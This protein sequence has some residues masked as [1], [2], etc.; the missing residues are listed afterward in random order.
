MGHE[1]EKVDR[2][3]VLEAGVAGVAL[4]VLPAACSS[5]T[6]SSTDAGTDVKHDSTPHD[7]PPPDVTPKDSAGDVYDPDATLVDG[8]DMCESEQTNWTHPINIM[9]AGIALKGTAYAFND[10]RFSDRYQQ[11]DRILVI[12]PLTGTGYVAM[13]G[14]CTHA[15]CCP[16][17][18]PKCI[19]STPES[20]YTA[21]C[22]P[23]PD[24]GLPDAG[25][26]GGIPDGSIE[27]P[28]GGYV[29]GG[30][31]EL[32]TDILFCPCH[33]S[34]YDA[35]TGMAIDGPAVSTGDLQIMNTCVG[36]G[37]VFVFIPDNG[38]EYGVMEPGGD[39]D[40]L[41][42]A[43]PPSS[44]SADRRGHDERHHL[45]TPFRREG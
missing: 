40:R 7:A 30:S 22:L 37:Y 17:Y 41:A 29:E 1:A 42:W 26:D 36:G 33:Q 31:P 10:P 25:P 3:Q 6:E 13:S 43:S 38:K 34:V 20:T 28:E 4:A 12:N 14:V 32:L 39:G 18:F 27:T 8:G 45:P 5:T 11:L 23:L 24:G 35:K 15:G 21:Q 2:R 44:R 19:Y 9:K 16:Q